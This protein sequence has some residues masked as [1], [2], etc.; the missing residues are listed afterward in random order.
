MLCFAQ[1]KLV[2]DVWYFILKSTEEIN[3]VKGV[4]TLLCALRTNLE[5]ST[6]NIIGVHYCTI[7]GYITIV[8]VFISNWKHFKIDGDYSLCATQDAA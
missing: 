8:V 3:Q 1:Q 5:E 6:L 4:V 7:V 2:F